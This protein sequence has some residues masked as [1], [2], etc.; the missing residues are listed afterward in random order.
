[1]MSLLIKGMQKTSL[2]DYPGKIA[3][4]VF[5]GMCN[6]SCPYCHNKNLVVGYD[7]LSTIKEKEVTDYLKNKKKW[8][9]GVCITGGEPMIHKEL[10]SFVSKIKNLGFLV[11]LDTNGSNPK[12]LK[13]L[14]DDKLVDYIAM[15]IKAPLEKYDNITRIKTNKNDIKESINLIKK[16]KIDNEFR[17]TVVP[18]LVNKDDIKE[19]GKLLKGAK[20]FFIQQFKANENVIDMAYRNKKSFS[21]EDLEEFKVILNKYINTVNVRGI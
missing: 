6:F 11:K 4:T 16:N 5:V 17:I 13:K 10:F 7:G 8:L 21:S 20:R 18:G 3:A 12:M 2:I 14:M 9:D 19:I 1:M 15:D